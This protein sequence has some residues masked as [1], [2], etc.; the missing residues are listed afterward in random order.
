MCVHVCVN[1][2]QHEGCGLVMAVQYHIWKA[3]TGKNVI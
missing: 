1:Q 3:D 2:I